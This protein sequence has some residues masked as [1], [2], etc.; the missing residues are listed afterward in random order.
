M[1]SS[2]RVIANTSHPAPDAVAGPPVLPRTH[3]VLRVAA[4]SPMARVL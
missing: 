1:R 4:C 3:A 2:E